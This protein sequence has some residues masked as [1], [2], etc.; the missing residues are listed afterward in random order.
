MEAWRPKF[1]WLCNKSVAKTRYRYIRIMDPH[2]F[3]A[4]PDSAFHFDAGPDTTFHSYADPD[5]QHWLSTV[6]C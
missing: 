1:N 4:D 6:C 5:P 3:N 2:H